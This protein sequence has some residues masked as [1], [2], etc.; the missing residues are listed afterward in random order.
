MRRFNYKDVFKKFFPLY[1][2]EHD[3]YKNAKGEGLLERLVTVCTEYF[4]TD[5]VV[6]SD[7]PGLDNFMDIIDFDLTPDIYLNYLWEYLGEIPYAWGVLTNG[8]PY[9]KENLREWLSNPQG[10]PKANSRQVLKYAIS[11]YKIRGTN[12]FYHI[13]GRIYGVEFE[14]ID[15]GTGG[16]ITEEDYVKAVYVSYSSEDPSVITEEN[17]ATWPTDDDPEGMVSQYILANSGN[18]SATADC[19]KCVQIKVNVKIQEG[20]YEAI[21]NSHVVTIE[22][23]TEAY[24]RI[25]EKYLPVFVQIATT[26]DGKPDINL[27]SISPTLLVR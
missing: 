5:V 6:N 23:V 18:A 3:S 9:S 27:V 13:L 21:Q 14:L 22:S 25:I 16:S 17:Y 11:L 2:Q 24:L 10:Y 20:T 7:N 19:L 4:D 8:K 26:E 12:V 15:L 1:F